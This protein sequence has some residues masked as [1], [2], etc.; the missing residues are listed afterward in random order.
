MSVTR[1]SARAQLA[2]ASLRRARA[3]C[4]RRDATLWHHTCVC[5][6]MQQTLVTRVRLRQSFNDSVG[7]ALWHHGW[8]APPEVRLL[9]SLFSHMEV[10]LT[11]PAVTS[12]ATEVRTDM[13]SVLE[14]CDAAL[15]IA[16]ERGDT[17]MEEI[18]ERVRSLAQN[19]KGSRHRSPS[20][21]KCSAKS[22]RTK[23]SARRRRRKVQSTCHAC[24]TRRWLSTG[25]TDDAGNQDERSRKTPGRAGCRE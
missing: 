12:A 6:C 21:K 19:Q 1:E 20:T 14:L 17:E 11:T 5:V 15:T 23:L 22:V 18:I 24:W 10:L 8:S 25:A 2:G 13:S 3:R 7:A 4:L 9:D 16:R